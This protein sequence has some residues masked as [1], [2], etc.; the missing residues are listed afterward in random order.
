MAFDNIQEN[1]ETTNPLRTRRYTATS[2]YLS[3][4]AIRQL[5]S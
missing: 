2:A 4:L 3:F 5:G 1:D